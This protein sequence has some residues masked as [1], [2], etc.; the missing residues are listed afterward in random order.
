[1][2]EPDGEVWVCTDCYFAHHYG[3]RR[4]VRE[5]TEAERNHWL[6]AEG[7]TYHARQIAGLWFN[8]TPEGLEVVEW[9]AG[10]SDSRCEGGEPLGY[11]GGLE[12]ADNTDS[13]TGAGIDGFSWSWCDG[14]HSTLGGS[15][16]RLAFWLKEPA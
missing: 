6:H 15:R 9:F 2:S 10:D 13:D 8:E 16:Y 1:M 7:N 4:I 14:C 12:L 5:A 11:L 3:A